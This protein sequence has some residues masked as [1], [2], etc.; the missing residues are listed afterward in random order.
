MSQV[1][2]IINLL[3]SGCLILLGLVILRESLAYEFKISFVYFIICLIAYVLIEDYYLANS[4]LFYLLLIFAISLPFAF[5]LLSLSIFEDDFELNSRILMLLGL[6][7][8]VQI[9]FYYIDEISRFSISNSLLRIFYLSRY[10][11]P[12]SFLVLGIVVAAKGRDGDL[13]I[14]RLRFRNTFIYYT[15]GLIAI[16]LVSEIAFA[17]I[18]IPGFLKMIQKSLIAILSF[19]F[20]S[21]LLEFR[22]GLISIR[23][24]RRKDDTK[25][26]L[27]P[28]PVMKE[29]EAIMELEQYWKTEGLTIRLLSEKLGVK[30][31]KLRQTINQ[32]LG[33][34]NFNDY[35]HSYRISEACNILNNP[36]MSEMTILEIA[37]LVGYNSLAP[38]NKAFKQITN[39]TPTEFRKQMNT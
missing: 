32:H 19:Y 13:L 9:S 38:F 18:S 5:W 14:N 39:L 33:Y 2:E 17:G 37:Y 27:L 30:E 8:L 11:L 35:L 21:S 4:F 23:V 1:L 16:T 10:I 12:I 24:N 36:Q 7:L 26:S 34:K 28:A 3:T 20:A 15:A 6:F 31:Y 29:L 25:V 22:N